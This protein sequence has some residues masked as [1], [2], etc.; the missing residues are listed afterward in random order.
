VLVL[1]PNSC[2]FKPLADTYI[3]IALRSPCAADQHSL[4]FHYSEPSSASQSDFLI[5]IWHLAGYGF[6][7]LGRKGQGIVNKVNYN[8]IALAELPLQYLG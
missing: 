5:A 1:L 6:S 3:S 7:R 4:G 8:G 2:F